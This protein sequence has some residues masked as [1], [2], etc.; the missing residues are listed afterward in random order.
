[1]GLLLSLL[2]LPIVGCV[3]DIPI[4]LR[5]NL[6]ALTEKIDVLMHIIDQPTAQVYM[7]GNGAWEKRFRDRFEKIEERQ[8]KVEDNLQNTSKKVRKDW[9]DQL[10]FIQDCIKAKKCPKD[11]DEWDSSLPKDVIMPKFYRYYTKEAVACEFALKRER[12]RLEN[13]L[14]ELRATPGAQ[15]K[16]YTD[17]KSLVDNLSGAKK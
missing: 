4:V 7:K 17:V 16:D 6:S 12:D 11:D 1:M 5:D 15:E 14:A 13:V 9:G 10:K 2:S 8:R 3:D